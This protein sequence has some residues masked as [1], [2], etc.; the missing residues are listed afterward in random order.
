MHS[1]SAISGTSWLFTVFGAN[2]IIQMDI[3]D[4]LILNHYKGLINGMTVLLADMQRAGGWMAFEP[5]L[6]QLIAD[7]NL[8]W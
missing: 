8:A 5:T 6:A 4:P 3:N 7:S 1:C 2:N